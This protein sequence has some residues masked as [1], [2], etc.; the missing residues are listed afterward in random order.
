MTGA[1]EKEMVFGK[2]W[3]DKNNTLLNF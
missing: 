2:T 1:S 3:K